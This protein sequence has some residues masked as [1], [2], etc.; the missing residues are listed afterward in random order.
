MKDNKQ[1]KEFFKGKKFF[2]GIKFWQ[3]QIVGIETL[4]STLK[5]SKA[6]SKQFPQKLHNQVEI[7]TAA[8]RMINKQLHHEIEQRKQAERKTQDVLE[9]LQSI[10][11]TV[12]EPLL[13]LDADLRVISASRSFYRFFKVKPEDTE[14]QHIYDLGNRQWNIPKLRELLEGVLPKTISFDN[15]EMEHNFPDIGKRIMLLNAR[16][17]YR[18]ATHT[19]YLACY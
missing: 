14:K 11:D 18:K 10:V 13:V 7:R 4:K 17:I 15:F 5:H 8:E 6:E 12:R 3:K 16:K 1:S 9:Y 2:E 19:A